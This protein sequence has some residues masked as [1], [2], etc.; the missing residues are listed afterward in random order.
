MSWTKEITIWCD[1]DGCEEWEQHPNTVEETRRILSRDGW[2]YTQEKDY[3]P[4][5]SSVNP[6]TKLER[7]KRYRGNGWDLI[8]VKEVHR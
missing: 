2:E 4:Q 8:D 5:H 3:C 1:K 6:E 7:I